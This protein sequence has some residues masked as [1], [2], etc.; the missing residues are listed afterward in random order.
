[1]RDLRALLRALSDQISIAKA[2]GLSTTEM[3]T[4]FRAATAGRI[5]VIV[6]LI[7]ESGKAAI[8]AGRASLTMGDLADAYDKLIGDCDDTANPFRADL[9]ALANG[10]LDD[11]RRSRSVG[12]KMNRR[13]RR[14]KKNTKLGDVLNNVA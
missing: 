1:V 2:A 14:T 6:E 5:G 10:V 3:A 9:I 4:R 13:I 12:R 7:E 8:R 11:Q